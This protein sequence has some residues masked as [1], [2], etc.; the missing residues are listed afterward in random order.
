MT[1]WATTTLGSVIP[2]VLKQTIPSATATLAPYLAQARAKLD[3]I[4]LDVNVSID[5]SNLVIKTIT[6]VLLGALSAGAINV[7]SVPIAKT[8]PQFQSD[9]PT[10]F[11]NIQTQLGIDLKAAGIA[12]SDNVDTAYKSLTSRSGGNAGFFNTFLSAIS[13]E[14]DSNRPQNF[15]VNDEV[16]MGVALVGATSLAA[17][18]PAANSF[19][20]IFKPAANEDP[21]ARIV[22]VPQSLKA[23]VV[24]KGTV[25]LNWDPPVQ[26]FTTPYFPTSSFNVTRYAV[27]R[28]TSAKL[29]KANSVLDLFPS[30]DL[31]EGMTSTDEAQ[32][33]KVVDIGSGA[34]S[35]LIDDTLIAGVTYYYAVAWEVQV[36]EGGSLQFSLS[37]PLPTTTNIGFDRLSGAIKVSTDAPTVTQNS[38]PPDWISSPSVASLI[39][40]LTDIVQTVVAKLSSI[41]DQLAT[42]GS[43]LTQLTNLAQANIDQL[44][45]R[46]DALSFQLS[47][48]TVTVSQPIPTLYATLIRGKGGNAYLIGEL[49]SRL[50]DM[51]DP[52]R[53]P[54]DNNEYVL[55][56]CVVAGGATKPDI[57][58]IQS[59]LS[60]FFGPSTPTNPLVNILN[61][62]SGAVAQAEAT[63]FGDSMQPLP[64]GSALPAVPPVNNTLT[65]AGIAVPGTD[66][67][68]P[69]TGITGIVPDADLC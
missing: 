40:G 56:V 29:L 39:P 16:V 7:L 33:Y 62:V 38:T 53:P 47:Q 55:G 67:G 18:I 2:S 9:A 10:S 21:T 4:N 65:D 66:A 64:S 51:S 25:K 60:S 23:V 22:P 54:F 31:V 52:N 27:I 63:V 28:S 46:V 30:R 26:Q 61:A 5:V 45:A 48:L 41:T 13:D 42:E 14:F 17:I 49:A 6:D 1:N 57:D 35:S 12:L 44:T 24:S 69:N 20:N 58:A 3:S 15:N 19:Y 36:N 43:P 59:L 32:Q 8:F 11:D 68:N 37:S 50:G 34:N